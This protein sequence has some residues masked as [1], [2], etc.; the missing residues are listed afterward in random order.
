MKRAFSVKEKA[1]LNFLKC[2]LLAKYIKIE[3]TSFKLL[4]VKILKEISFEEYHYFQNVFT[5]LGKL[6]VPFEHYK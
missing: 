5:Y 2:F 6:K 3:Y 4:Y 1:F